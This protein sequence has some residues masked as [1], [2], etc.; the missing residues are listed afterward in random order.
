MNIR[1]LRRPLASSA[2][3]VLFVEFSTVHSDQRPTIEILVDRTERV[4]RDEAHFSLKATN[5]SDRPVFLTGIDW[6]KV[7]NRSDRPVSRGVTND[8]LGW[9][10]DPVHLEQWRTEK[11][12]KE[13]YCSDTPPPDVIKLNP[14]E[15][16]TEV[17]WLKLPMSVICRNPITELE[18]KFRFRV[19]YFE[20]EKQ[21]RAY[22]EKLFSPRW[23]EARATVAFSEPFEIPLPQSGR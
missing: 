12:W 10:L 17:L 23:K 3:L 5:R 21:A 19:E 2:L 15:V 7:T 16:I 11:G 9:R 8:E 4:S 18:G 1:A 13:A 22:I 20:S 6:R 14:G